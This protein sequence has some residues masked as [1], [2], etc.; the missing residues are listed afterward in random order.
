[1]LFLQDQFREVIFSHT[2]MGNMDEKTLLRRINKDE[3]LK[4]E[5]IHIFTSAKD[6]L[7][8]EMPLKALEAFV[9]SLVNTQSLFD[10]YMTGDTGQVAPAISRGFN[11]FMG[12][13]KCGTCHFMPAFNGVQPPFFRKE[14]NEIIGVLRNNDFDR[15]VLD[16]DFGLFT[17]THNDLHRASFKVPSVRH[18]AKTFPYMHNGSLKNLDQV[19]LFYNLGGGGGWMMGGEVPGQ[20]LD[21]EPLKLDK[22]QRDDIKAFLLSLE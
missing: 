16:T 5:L 22:E 20:T 12:A 11:L 13:A 7:T 21:R 1:M 4:K 15:P 17:F 10:R 8:V 14:E 18:L 9:H 19:L 3:K 6:S 2:E